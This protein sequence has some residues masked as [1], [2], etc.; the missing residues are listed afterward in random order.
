MQDQII[1]HNIVR[2]INGMTD[3]G[4]SSFDISGQPHPHPWGF[5]REGKN[6]DCNCFGAEQRERLKDNNKTAQEIVREAFAG[7]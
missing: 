5:K 3:N 2:I 1:S 7:I 4:K 6:E